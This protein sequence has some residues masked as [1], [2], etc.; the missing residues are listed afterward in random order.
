MAICSMG[1]GH[2][3]LV[4][5]ADFLDDRLQEEPGSDPLPP[6]HI[7][8]LDEMIG[9]ALNPKTAE[10]G[11]KS[12]SDQQDKQCGDERGQMAK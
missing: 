10:N 4:A 3:L 9:R 2:A 6:A 8:L 1:C 7:R 5:D 12:P 11:K